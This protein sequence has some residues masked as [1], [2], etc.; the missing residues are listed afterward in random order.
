MMTGPS[1]VD[2]YVELG[3][4]A[5]NDARAQHQHDLPDQRGVK[6]PGLFRR[7]LQVV[8]PGSRRAIFVAHQLH[9]Q[10]ALV[11]PVGVRHAHSGGGEFVQ[12]VDLGTLPG[13]FLFLAAIA[14]AFFHRARLAAVL[15]LAAFG[16][17]DRLVEA[18]LV[19]FLVDLC[20]TYLVAALDDIDRGFLSAHQLAQDAVYHAVL[21]E[22]LDSLGD[23]H[24]VII[25]M[26][27]DV[28]DSR[29]NPFTGGEAP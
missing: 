14:R 29:K 5:V 9:Q 10:H 13:R 2:E 11:K 8:E 19:G 23:F 21:D 17:M 26:T 22:R 4:V 12:G 15:Y 3:Q 16:V 7:E 18:A 1:A 27:G 25:C 24:R 28:N 6:F 20:A